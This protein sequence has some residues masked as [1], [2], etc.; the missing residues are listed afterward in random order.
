[1]K[2]NEFGHT[3]IKVSEIG[4][5]GSRI[6]GLLAGKSSRSETVAL[7]QNALAAG[8]TFYDTADMYAQGE[9]EAL[10]GTAFRAR[11]HEVVLATKGGFSLPA[12]RRLLA[13][14]KP[15]VR[16]VVQALGLKRNKIV[17][18]VAGSLSQNFSPAYLTDAVHGSLR[19]LQTDYIDLYQLHSP[20]MQ[21]LESEVLGEAVATL[22]KLKIQGKLRH[23]GIATEAPEDANS[24]LA[25]SGISSVQLGFGLLDPEALDQGI[26]GGAAERG[27]GVIVRGCY[28]GGLLKDGLDEAGLKATTPKWDQ[29][30]AIRAVSAQS[31][32][33]VLE[34]ALKFCLGTPGI[35][36]TLLGMH[37]QAHLREN[38]RAYRAPPLNAEEYATARPRAA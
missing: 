34:T 5:G 26:L 12:Q 28:G 9:S 17:A 1:M 15:I 35:S 19:R 10:M 18:S 22:E 24:C 7:L 37:T 16:P 27:L 3:G 11:R 8:I 30:L 2:Y 13:R 4:F 6:G 21:R 20:P 25:V 31:G 38:M 23:Y 14:I 36:V 33:A 29:I 32:R